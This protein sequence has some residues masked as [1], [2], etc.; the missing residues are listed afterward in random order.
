MTAPNVGYA[1]LLDHAQEGYVPVLTGRALAIDVER[2]REVVGR[3][4]AVADEVGELHRQL[5]AVR[6]EPPANDDVSRNAAVQS[7]RMVT[8][9]RSYLS[10]W[11]QDIVTSI[12]ALKQQIDDYVAAD[13]GNAARA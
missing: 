8:A 4:E 2:A 9:G 5:S 1:R 11:H 12:R 7:A 3:L 6:I 10:A 13:R